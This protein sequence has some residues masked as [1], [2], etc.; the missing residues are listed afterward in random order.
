MAGLKGG[1]VDGGLGPNP[2]IQFF[3]NSCLIR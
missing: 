1:G 2:T 3:H